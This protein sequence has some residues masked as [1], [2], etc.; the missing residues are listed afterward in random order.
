MAANMQVCERVDFML[1]YGAFECNQVDRVQ[2]LFLRNEEDRRECLL[3]VMK[4]V[5]KTMNEAYIAF[6]LLA[7]VKHLARRQ[8][9]RAALNP[10]R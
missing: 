5:S 6:Q 3:D 1:R 2:T 9:G 8:A 7:S 4:K 10:Y